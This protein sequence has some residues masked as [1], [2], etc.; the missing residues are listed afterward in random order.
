M[1]PP[2]ETPADEGWTEV[3]ADETA[4]R[5]SESIA[6]GMAQQKELL[7]VVQK[8]M[9]TARKVVLPMVQR[10]TLP[11][12]R[13]VNSTAEGSTESIADSTVDGWYRQKGK[14]MAQQK[15][16]SRIQ[17]A[18]GAEEC[19]AKGTAEVTPKG[20]LELPL[21]NIRREVARGVSDES[22]DGTTRTGTATSSS[23]DGR[24]NN[25]I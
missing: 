4:K 21:R 13:S 22:V 24:S 8:E 18:D 10:R 11:A 15:F 3:I 5:V 23:T 1:A 17:T 7:A 20:Q 12:V 14:S 16:L 2:N 9:S 19:P 25:L 6:D